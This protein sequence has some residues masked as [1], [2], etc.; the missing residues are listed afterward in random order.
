[1]MLNTRAFK[2]VDD[3]ACALESADREDAA[4]PRR[5]KARRMEERLRAIGREK[6]VPLE[7]RTWNCPW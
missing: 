6:D 2:R 3:L 1:M 5:D 7:L 4:P